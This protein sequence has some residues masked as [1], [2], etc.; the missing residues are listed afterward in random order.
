MLRLECMCWVTPLAV[1]CILV[2]NCFVFCA[3]VVG[4]MEIS[5]EQAQ[6]AHHPSKSTLRRN[7]YIC[8]VAFMMNYAAYGG[9][10]SVW[11]CVC[12]LS[13]TV[14][15][16]PRGRTTTNSTAQAQTRQAAKRLNYMGWGWKTKRFKFIISQSQKKSQVLSFQHFSLVAMHVHTRHVSGNV[17]CCSKKRTIKLVSAVKTRRLFSLFR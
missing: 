2:P 6:Q 8:A 12:A 7:L 17:R 15:L 10:R 3:A 9:I 4:L 14:L 13:F 5:E 1:Q 16:I 11:S